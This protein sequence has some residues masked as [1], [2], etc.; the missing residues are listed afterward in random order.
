MKQNT[1]R[2]ETFFEEEVWNEY[3][4]NNKWLQIYENYMYVNCDPRS[5]EY[6]LVSSE[7]KAAKNS[8]P[9]GIWT[10]NLCDAGAAL[11]QLN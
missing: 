10:H 5:Y 7:N 4:S 6:Y 1:W 8:G 11:Y 3:D 9:Y 2:F